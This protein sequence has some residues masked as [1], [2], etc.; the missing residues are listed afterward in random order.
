M[1][2]QRRFLEEV[3]CKQGVEEVEG[4]S[5]V[6]LWGTSRHRGASAKAEGGSILECLRAS[7][8]PDGWSRRSERSMAGVSAEGPSPRGL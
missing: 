2:F 5:H 8:S 3:T 7:K 4:D 1:A 6:A